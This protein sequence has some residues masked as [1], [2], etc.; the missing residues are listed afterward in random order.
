MEGKPYPCPKNVECFLHL[1]SHSSSQ[2]GPFYSTETAIGI[3]IGT[4]NGN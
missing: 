3:I 4:G 2:F 1:N